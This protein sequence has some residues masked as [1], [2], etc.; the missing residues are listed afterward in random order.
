M[1]GTLI[2]AWA[3]QKSFGGGIVLRHMRRHVDGAKIGHMIGR[4]VRL[5]LTDR[6]AVAGS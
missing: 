6:D 1:D 4:V 2:E 3:S 5:V